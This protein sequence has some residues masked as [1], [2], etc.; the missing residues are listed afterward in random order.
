MATIL[1]GIRLEQLSWSRFYEEAKL[2]LE[3]QGNEVA[4]VYDR[5]EMY[6]NLDLEMQQA[7]YDNGNLIILG[8]YDSD[9]IG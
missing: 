1:S 6:F 9:L 5:P 8:A 4:Q 3:L 7:Y 2:L